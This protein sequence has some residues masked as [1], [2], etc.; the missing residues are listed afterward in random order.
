MPS[1]IRMK[2]QYYIHQR[3]NKKV[4]NMISFRNKLENDKN[5]INLNLNTIISRKILT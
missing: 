5:K 4:V 2:I 1:D 3:L